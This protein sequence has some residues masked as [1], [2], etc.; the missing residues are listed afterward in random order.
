MSHPRE[1][2]GLDARVAS[3]RC[4]AHAPGPWSRCTQHAH[5]TV[6]I[7]PSQAPRRSAGVASF[8][9]RRNADGGVFV[10]LCAS[11]VCDLCGTLRQGLISR[12]GLRAPPSLRHVSRRGRPLTPRG[13]PPILRRDRR[14]VPTLCSAL[15]RFLQSS[16]KPLHDA[17]LDVF[18]APGDASPRVSLAK[19]LE[20]AIE[21]SAPEFIATGTMA[22][23]SSSS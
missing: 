14:G 2:T 10:V 6:P 8:H 15:E 11:R 20:F 3:N 18:F 19:R 1:G 22:D 13:A 9:F 12:R 17:A 7:L 21:P 16:Q 4:G 5:R 23:S